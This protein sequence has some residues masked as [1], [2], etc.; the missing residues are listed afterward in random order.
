MWVFRYARFV[1]VWQGGKRSSARSQSRQSYGSQKLAARWQPK[2]PKPQK[3]RKFVE[4]CRRIG[5]VLLLLITTP[6]L[7]VQL[8]FIVLAVVVVVIITI[9]LPR[10][11]GELAR[12]YR[13]ATSNGKADRPSKHTR[14]G[15]VRQAGYDKMISATR[16]GAS[17]R[18]D[19]LR[20]RLNELR[21]VGTGHPAHRPRNVGGQYGK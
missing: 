18:S 11:F 10:T 1:R 14:G 8:G 13:V 16:F 2:S 7:F 3:L 12:A 5:S 21:S 17:T 20:R 19:D 15:E 4:R 6:I 9:S